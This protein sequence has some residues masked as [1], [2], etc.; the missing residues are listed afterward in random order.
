MCIIAAILVD[1]KMVMHWSMVAWVVTIVFAYGSIEDIAFA[2]MK[3]FDRRSNDPIGNSEISGSDI[4]K[5][6]P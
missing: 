3:E 2:T 4:T 6:G 1:N 5:A